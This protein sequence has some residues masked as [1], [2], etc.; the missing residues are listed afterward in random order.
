MYRVFT[1]KLSTTIIQC[2]IIVQQYT[3]YNNTTA[4]VNWSIHLYIEIKLIDSK[5][6]IVDIYASMEYSAVYELPVALGHLE[7]SDDVVIF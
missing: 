4:Y 3:Q 5:K 6:G 1:W 7:Y 2:C